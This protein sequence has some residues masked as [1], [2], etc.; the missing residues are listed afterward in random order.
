VVIG[1]VDCQKLRIIRNHL[2]V[3][4]HKRNRLHCY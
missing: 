3:D 4:N 2:K 1:G